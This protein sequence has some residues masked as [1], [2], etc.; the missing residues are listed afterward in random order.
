MMRCF[1]DLSDDH[2]A[3]I[4]EWTR[5][6][7]KSCKLKVALQS[8]TAHLPDLQDP[9]TFHSVSSR[10]AHKHEKADNLWKLGIRTF[11]FNLLMTEVSNFFVAQGQHSS[12]F[13]R[14]FFVDFII[15]Y[16][17]FCKLQSVILGHTQLSDRAQNYIKTGPECTIPLS[18]SGAP[19][20]VEM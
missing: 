4:L 13:P 8:I 16:R 9:N 5:H 2:F 3:I 10:S 7:H 15:I 17:T 6:N 20:T 18:V 19:L 12:S 11:K 1:L 14:H